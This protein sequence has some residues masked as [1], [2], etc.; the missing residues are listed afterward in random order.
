MTL[1]NTLYFSWCG[2][3]SVE[4][5]ATKPGIGIEFWYHDNPRALTVRY[6]VQ[7]LLTTA[8]ILEYFKMYVVKY[9]SHSRD[10][11]LADLP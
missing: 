5:F 10:N 7:V 4:Y 3:I 2:I 6:H 1:A 8:E 11:L 9:S